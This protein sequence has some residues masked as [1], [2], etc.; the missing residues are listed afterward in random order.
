MKS[1]FC[2]RHFNPPCHVSWEDEHPNPIVKVVALRS[3]EILCQSRIAGHSPADP[4]VVV[5]PEFKCVLHAD[6]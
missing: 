3:L 1:K 4:C 2:R 5:P 6:I